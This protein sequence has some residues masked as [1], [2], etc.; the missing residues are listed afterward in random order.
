MIYEAAQSKDSGAIAILHKKGIPT[1]FL[2][3]LDIRLLESLYSYMIKNEIVLVARDGEIIAG[4][5]SATLNLKRLYYKF[6]AGN[7][8]LVA[9]RMISLSL[10]LVFF[11]KIIETLRIPFRKSSGHIGNENLPELLSIV[12]DDLFRG[13]GIGGELVIHLEARLKAVEIKKYRVV[14]GDMLKVAQ[15]FYSSLGFVED[16]ADELH[17]G[18]ISHILIKK[19][20]E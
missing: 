3:S 2:S 10:T 17:K 20:S 18:E 13:K 6:L 1:G 8:F 16:E 5:V 14:V 11:R 9:I 7:F 19:I 12:I 15:K 4:F